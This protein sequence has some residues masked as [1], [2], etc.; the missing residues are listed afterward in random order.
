[1]DGHAEWY[2]LHCFSSSQQP[3]KNNF[4]KPTNQYQ[5][6]QIVY[7]RPGC[8]RVHMIWTDSPCNVTCWNNGN[9]FTEA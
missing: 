5:F 4:R 9:L 6:D 1:M 8:S 2:G 3:D 7:P